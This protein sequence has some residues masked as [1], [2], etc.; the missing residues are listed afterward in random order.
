MC[1]KVCF[2]MRLRWLGTVVTS[3]TASHGQ[4]YTPVISM[5]QKAVQSTHCNSCN[6]PAD[7]QPATRPSPVRPG[8]AGEGCVRMADKPPTV[9]PWLCTS[10]RGI[11]GCPGAEIWVATPSTLHRSACVVRHFRLTMSLSVSLWRI[12][13]TS[14]EC[15]EGPCG[16]FLDWSVSKRVHWAPAAAADGRA[17]KHRGE[18]G[19]DC[20]SGCQGVGF[21]CNDGKD[22][23]FDIWVLNLMHPAIKTPKSLV[24]TVSMNVRR[25][26]SMPDALLRPSMG[27]SRPW[28]LRHPGHGT[29]GNDLFPSPCWP[30]EREAGIVL[31]RHHE[32]DPPLPV[33]FSS[34]IFSFLHRRHS[35]HSAHFL[36]HSLQCYFQQVLQKY[37]NSPRHYSNVIN[38]I[39][40]RK[41]QHF[42]VAAELCDLTHST[43]HFQS[44]L[45]QPGLSREL[46]NGPA[47]K[48]S[49][50]RLC[51]F[52]P[53]SSWEVR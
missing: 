30:C 39:T 40:G 31:L 45:F 27:A 1:Q 18:H 26:R 46:P 36:Q 3:H 25:S 20:P 42:S 7:C 5:V 47:T 16:V 4:S 19:G 37:K 11:S 51:E 24:F 44:L 9:V 23:F 29:W 2:W 13:H 33:F 41:S 8:G 48:H 22:A 10:Q 35:F 14:P 12:S 21:L 49:H 6:Q 38:H 32:L 53:V 34:P 52:S 28:C 17:T 50:N 43:D 15:G